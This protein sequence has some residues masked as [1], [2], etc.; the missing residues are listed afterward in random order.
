VFGLG[1]DAEHRETGPPGVGPS[2]PLF[3]GPGVLGRG[4]K[5][6]AWAGPTSVD[7]TRD[8]VGVAGVSGSQDIPAHSEMMGVGVFGKG[9]AVGVSGV[10]TEVLGRGGVF[11]CASAAQVRLQPHEE[12]V[13]SPIVD[14]T[15]K[16][17]E[18]YPGR[19]E[20]PPANLPRNGLPGDL[21]ATTSGFG[22]KDEKATLWFC[23]RGRVGG[24]GGEAAAQWREVLMGPAFPGTVEDA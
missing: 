18:V 17:F 24:E 12:P 1:G 2:G 5:P 11:S 23:Q 15:P 4:G 14:V 9:G 3:A 21:L 7:P 8:G 10:S 19:D 16:G 13:H 22:N 6:I 20:S